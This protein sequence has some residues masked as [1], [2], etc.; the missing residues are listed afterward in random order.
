MKSLKFMV[1]ALA[2]LALL[3][4]DTVDEPHYEVV[5]KY[6]DFELRRYDPYLVAE[7]EVES[8]FYN[9]AN[10]AF[11]RLADY[12]GGNNRKQ[13]E[14]AMTSPVKQQPAEQEGEKIDMTA[15]VRQAPASGDEDKEKYVISFV[16]PAKYTM[17][18]IPE[19]NDSRVKIRKVPSQLVAVRQYSGTWGLK[20][21]LENE[22]ILLAA[23]E[24]EGLEKAGEAV[25]ARYDPPWSLWFM[26]RNEV[27][28]EVKDKKAD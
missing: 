3:G 1:L 15:P 11:Q 20:N 24:R 18:N 12:I 19:P 4:A 16:M 13:E 8:G 10:L 26:R 6:E 2:S 28:V 14:I 21:Y 9:A 25:F 5:K 7:T 23:I 27:M 22:A 17:E